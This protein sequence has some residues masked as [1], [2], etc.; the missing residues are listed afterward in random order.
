MV[1]GLGL[2]RV[3]EPGLVLALVLVLR[4]GQGI[5]H[6]VNAECRARSG[7]RKNRSG[8]ARARCSVRTGWTAKARARGEVVPVRVLKTAFRGTLYNLCYLRLAPA[9]GS[10]PKKSASAST[11]ALAF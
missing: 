5:R 6:R 11:Q 3:L 10:D 1:S 4:V 7:R 9:Q 2:W 8:R